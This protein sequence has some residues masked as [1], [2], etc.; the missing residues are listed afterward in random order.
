[1]HLLDTDNVTLLF[2]GHPGV[3]HHLQSHP[4]DDVGTTIVT[5]AEILRGR[6][7]FLLKAADG[8]QFRKADDLLRRTQD[9]LARMPV[10]ATDAPAANHFDRLR[11]ARGLRKIDHADL[12]FASIV[13]ARKATLVTRN[14]RH[15]RLIPG[16]QIGNWAD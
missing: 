7:E 8:P 2:E 4:A 3:V 13:L 11:T 10:I 16:L 12:L 9:F 6:V 14:L 5:V 15:F 1:M